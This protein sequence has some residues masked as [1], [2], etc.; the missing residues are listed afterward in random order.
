MLGDSYIVDLDKGFYD[1]TV[2]EGKISFRLC[3]N[4]LLK[5]S[6]HWT[7]DVRRISPTPSLIGT[8]NAVEFRAAVE[9]ARQRARIRNHSLEESAS[10]S[11]AAD[12]VKLKWHKN[13]IT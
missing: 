3:W 2:A 10:L 9:A 13:W 5:A 1:K 8:S 7:Q 11:K 12:T 4:N 6:I